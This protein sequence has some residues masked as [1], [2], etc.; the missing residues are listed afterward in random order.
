MVDKNLSSLSVSYSL[1]LFSVI[2]LGGTFSQQVSAQNALSQDQAPAAIEWSSLSIEGWNVNI[3]PRLRELDAQAL[4]LA[5]ELLK[6]QLQ[7]IDRVVPAQAVK[8]LRQVTLWISPEYPGVSPRAEYHPGAGWL[9]KNGRD[10]AMVKGVEFTNVR[11]FEAETRRMPNFALHELAHAY[12]DQVLG[13]DNKEVVAAFERAKASGKYDRVE[14]QDSEGRKRQ[15][16]AY[17]LTSPQEYFAETSEA[18]FSQND[19]QPYNRSELEAFDPT[20]FQLLQQLWR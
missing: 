20:M 1:C 11:V 18:F 13:Y 9:R 7:E 6:K 8:K 16:R 15:D 19:F 14:R 2:A 12:H 10:P 4:A 3:N 17:A 5:L